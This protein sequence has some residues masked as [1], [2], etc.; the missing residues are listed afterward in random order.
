MKMY[1]WVQVSCV[2]LDRLVDLCLEFGAESGAVA[3][4][5]MTGGGFGGCVVALV[6]K[7][8][9]DSLKKFLLVR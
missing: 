5:R 8:S 2:E 4:A 9:V 3:G 7:D 6:R 1:I